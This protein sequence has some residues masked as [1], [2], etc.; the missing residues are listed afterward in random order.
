MA[1]E[2]KK[3]LRKA[4]TLDASDLHLTV[5]SPPVYRVNGQ[6]IAGG[7]EILTAENIEQMAKEVMREQDWD[8]F[9]TGLELDFS[10]QLENLSRFRMNAFFQREAISLVAR[11]IPKNIPTLEQLNMPT[12]LQDLA[13]KPYGMVIVTGPTGSGKSTTLTAMI[14]YINEREAKHIITLEDPIEFEHKHKKSIINQREVGLDTN[15]FANGLKSALRQDPDI[16]LVGEMRD[17][18]TIETA[19]TAAETGHLVL[20]T[21]HT[22][23]AIETVNRIIGVF[24]PAQQ[25]QIRSQ[26]AA[27]LNGVIS[28]RLFLTPDHSGRVAA[29]EILINLPSV[30]NLIRN[31]KTD[32]IHNI[33]QTS[34]AQGM[35]TLEMAIRDLIATNKIDPE[36]AKMFLS[37]AGEM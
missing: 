6:L 34:R 1:Y 12:V 33:L 24:P 26:L 19:I 30:A 17:I 3:L 31:E 9:T 21:L 20:A 28:Q 27:V 13:L 2:I 25:P 8:K 29:T 23:T 15:S 5:N 11:V 18:E 10:Y 32:Q 4:L 37:N 22:S 36:S 7:E 35:H 16:I 14:D